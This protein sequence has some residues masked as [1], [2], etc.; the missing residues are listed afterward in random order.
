MK[1]TLDQTAARLLFESQNLS[2]AQ[3]LFSIK[4]LAKAAKKS[5]ALD[6]LLEAEYPGIPVE[7][8]NKEQ[9]LEVW[10]TVKGWFEMSELEQRRTGIQLVYSNDPS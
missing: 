10:F 1:E 5:R 6:V 7:N 9:L 2:E 8:L 4:K 3:L